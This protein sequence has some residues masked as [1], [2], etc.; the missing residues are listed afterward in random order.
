M[1]ADI[2][3]LFDHDMVIHESLA[4]VTEKDTKF[5][6]QW[7]GLPAK[8]IDGKVYRWDREWKE[9]NEKVDVE[10]IDAYNCSCVVPLFSKEAKLDNGY[11]FLV[12]LSKDNAYGFRLP[13]LIPFDF[14]ELQYERSLSPDDFSEFL[15]FQPNVFG[16]MLNNGDRW[17]NVSCTDLGIKFRYED[18]A[19]VLGVQEAPGEKGVGR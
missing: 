13:M 16:V 19:P 17:C 9:C 7:Y 14:Y 8:V 11:Y 3:R 4:W 12:G 1:L 18:G 5:Y 10:Y 15:K 6:M 2:P